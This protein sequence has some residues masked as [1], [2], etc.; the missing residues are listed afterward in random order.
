MELIEK[1][2]IVEKI[3]TL[4]DVDLDITMQDINEAIDSCSTWNI[5]VE[6]SECDEKL[7]SPCDKFNAYEMEDF[8]YYA[9][10]AMIKFGGSFSQG[11]GYAL[12]SA[13]PQNARLLARIFW[14]DIKQNYELYMKMPIENVFDKQGRDNN[15]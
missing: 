13:T 12:Q 7:I 10:Q 5:D 4:I 14:E 15:E 1:K 8:K 6:Q 9:S 3:K 11:I 2:E